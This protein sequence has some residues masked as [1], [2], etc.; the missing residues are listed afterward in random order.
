MVELNPT[1]ERSM[2]RHFLSIAAA[3]LVLPV[4]GG[5]QAP[6]HHSQHADHGDREIK[7]LSD[8]EVVDLLEGAGMGYALAAELN[9]YPGPRHVLDL[10]GELSLTESQIEDVTRVL[11]EMNERARELG[12]RLVAAERDLDELFRTR[13]ATGRAVEERV[14]AIAALEGEVRYVHLEAHLQTTALLTDEQ[15]L[16]YDMER[17]YS[18]DHGAHGAH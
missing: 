18:H 1:D 14:L 17:G 5:A 2:F 12:T 15:I 7:A 13:S 9:S 6:A 11:E 3:L 4:S 10:E 8:Q 16:R